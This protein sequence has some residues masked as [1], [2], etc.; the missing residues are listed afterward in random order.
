M[1]RF[2]LITAEAD[3]SHADWLFFQ[4][5]VDQAASSQRSNDVISAA[6]TET[7]R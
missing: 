6:S 5:A 1:P 7:Y 3:R 4:P 2:R